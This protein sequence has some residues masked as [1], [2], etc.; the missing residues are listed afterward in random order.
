MDSRHL[1]IFDGVCNFCN[2]AVNFIIQRDPAGRFAFT[3]MQSEL[4]Q[5]T[6]R[7]YGVMNVGIDTFLLVKDGKAFL[8][9]TAALEITRDLNG[10]WSLFNLFRVV[11]RPIRD[12]F[13]RLFARN[14]YAL[15]GRSATC[16]VPGPEIRDRFVG[17]SSGVNLE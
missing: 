15:F 14:R 8:Y 9:S 11:P 1:I 12:W 7:A 10:Y 2:G 17:V 13:Y 16:R 3:P 5:Q 6:M 4:A